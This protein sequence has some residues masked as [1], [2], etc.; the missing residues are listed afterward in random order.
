MHPKSFHQ[1]LK[2]EIEM[3]QQDGYF[4]ITTKFKNDQSGRQSM[5]HSLKT[6]LAE[7]EIAGYNKESVYAKLKKPI[8]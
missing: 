7:T 1:S 6:D 3:H 2:S 4:S 8:R 5:G